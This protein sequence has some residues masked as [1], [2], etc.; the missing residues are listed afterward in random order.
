MTS[1]LGRAPGWVPMEAMNDADAAPT[2]LRSASGSVDGAVKRAGDHDLT[3]LMHMFHQR[4]TDREVP[5]LLYSMRA[6][7]RR[8][9]SAMTSTTYVS[10]VH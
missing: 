6:A 8:V 10:G 3:K 1:G 2:M 5:V 9:H 4:G 7:T